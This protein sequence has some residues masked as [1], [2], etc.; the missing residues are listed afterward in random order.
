MKGKKRKMSH[1]EFMRTLDKNIRENK[2]L[3]P[4]EKKA[5][6]KDIA[7]G[8][9]RTREFLDELYGDGV[10]LYPDTTKYA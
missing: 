3:S 4:E 6:K 8:E 5:E 1:A 7:K 9:K 2:P 10:V